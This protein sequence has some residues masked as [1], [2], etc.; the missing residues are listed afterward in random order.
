[1]TT[2]NIWLQSRHG[3][4]S[5]ASEASE[6]P[7]EASFDDEQNTSA[8]SGLDRALSSLAILRGEPDTSAAMSVD[9]ISFRDSLS[10]LPESSSSGPLVPDWDSEMRDADDRTDSQRD[11][12]NHVANIPRYTITDEDAPMEISFTEGMDIS[13][14]V[15]ADSEN[16]SRGASSGELVSAGNFFGFGSEFRE[17]RLQS[18]PDD[19]STTPAMAPAPEPVAHASSDQSIEALIAKHEAQSAHFDSLVDA[20]FFTNASGTKT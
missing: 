20:G 2:R 1:M 16:M 19:T 11:A 7:S 3:D 18:L 6:N 10:D 8:A 9:G 13:F 5:F 4:A 17:Q 15:D 12:V 14:N